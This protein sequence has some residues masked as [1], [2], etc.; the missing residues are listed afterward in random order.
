MA[1]TPEKKVKDKV[2]KLLKAHTAYYF[3]PSTHG[4]GVSG[5]F[6]ICVVYKGHFIGI[7]TKSDCKKK[8]T[9]LQSLNAMKAMDAGASILLIHNENVDVL[10]NLLTEIDN[11][12]EIKLNRKCVWAFERNKAS[13]IG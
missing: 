13:S 8:P 5:L 6:D 7:E 11:D 9:E 4:F 12:S 10:A 2:V 1:L 3:Y